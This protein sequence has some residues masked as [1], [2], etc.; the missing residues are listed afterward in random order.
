MLK[1]TDVKCNVIW[2]A[3]EAGASPRHKGAMLSLRDS[4]NRVRCALRHRPERLWLAFVAGWASALWDWVASAGALGS[5]L[6][7]LGGRPGA[8]IGYGIGCRS[9]V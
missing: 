6:W 2:G 5:G 9:F 4:R 7:R 8:R 3:A 1:K